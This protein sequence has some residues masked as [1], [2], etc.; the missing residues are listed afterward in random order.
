MS[1]V[2]NHHAVWIPCMSVTKPLLSHHWEWYFSVVTEERF[3]HTHAGNPYSM[4]IC[5]EAAPFVEPLQDWQLPE[6]SSGKTVENCRVPHFLIWYWVEVQTRFAD[7]K[8][9]YAFWQLL[10]IMKTDENSW[11]LIETQ[12]SQHALGLKRLLASFASKHGSFYG[13]W[14][15]LRWSFPF[16]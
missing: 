15:P 9:T 11:S 14:V 13:I 7:I 16:R 2:T 3:R 4:V 12:Q 6:T 5:D 1:L 8:A 10:V